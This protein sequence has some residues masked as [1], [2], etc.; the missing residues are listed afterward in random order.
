VLGPDHELTLKATGHL[1]FNLGE[2]GDRSAAT[3]MFQRLI[4]DLTR[5]LGP[6]HQQT[7][8]ARRLLAVNVG[9]DGDRAEAVRL[10]REVVADL[11]RALGPEHQ[12][13]RKAR[14]ELETF[15]SGGLPGIV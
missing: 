9:A 14:C 2:R 3:A 7:L 10:L 6:D 1:A 13:T 4:A 15:E 8:V 11:A 5:T 12:Q